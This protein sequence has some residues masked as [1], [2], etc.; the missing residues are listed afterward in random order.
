[1]NYRGL[2]VG[3]GIVVGPVRRMFTVV[4]E[5]ADEVSALSL[6]DERVRAR[7]ALETVAVELESRA[8]Q[9]GGDAAD[10]LA[11]QAMMARDPDVWDDIEAL[12][13]QRKTAEWA[14]SQ[15]F[16][17]FVGMLKSLGGTQAER[18]ADLVDVSRRT[19]AI[20]M[21][22]PYGEIPEC[23]EPYVLVAEDLAPADTAM[24]DLSC[25]LALV[26]SGGSPTAHTAIL[27]RAKGLV[28]VVSAAGVLDIPDGEIVVVD[29]AEG[30][31]ECAPDADRIAEV[32]ERMSHEDDEGDLSDGQ[33][34]DG[35]AIPLLANVGSLGNVQNAL[36]KG[37]EGV[38]LLRTEFLF[39]EEDV[40]PSVEE[41]T[42]RYRE[43]LVAL[44]GRKAVARTL[45]AGADK[46]LA[47]LPLGKED[48]PALGVRGIR[49][50]HKHEQLLRDQLESLSAAGSAVPSDLWVMAPMVADATEA[51]WFA[52]MA[53]EAGIRTVGVMIE[54]P[55]CAVVADQVFDAVDFVS[56]GTND[57]TQYALAADRQNGEVAAYQDAWHP[58]VLRLIRMVG[59]AA[60]ASK[61]PLSVC[62]EAA[63]DPL[64]AVILVGLG[65]TS[66]SMVP[67]ALREVR[68]TLAKYSLEEARVLAAIA[69]DARSAADARSRVRDALPRS[70][71]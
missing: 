13:V 21:D 19:V 68:S 2:G 27:A 52:S 22:V 54:V 20:I 39:F 29:A 36:A 40:A 18:A 65:V 7:E 14:V 6:K 12:L 60:T 69:L 41:Q 11:A 62:G 47:F 4:P 25:V 58:A 3:L 38:G 51:E 45:D 66:L 28:A 34:S 8:R 67:N 70:P 44:D 1:M 16:S 5:P 10:V 49:T 56:I 24:L 50:V 33:L 71:R 30:T 31:I 15:A 23:D 32:R 35:T 26:T 17:A 37:A 43:I 61:K 48:N 59:D 57:L 9:A 63:S 42:A 53:R 55:S 46:P 64:L